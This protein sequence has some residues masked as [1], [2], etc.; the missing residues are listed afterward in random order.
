MA[1]L[2]T[3]ERQRA[4]RVPPGPRSAGRTTLTEQDVLRTSLVIYETRVYYTTGNPP[5][6]LKPPAPERVFL[7]PEST[8]SY[9]SL[10]PQ[11]T[12]GGGGGGEVVMIL[13]LPPNTSTRGV[14]TGNGVRNHQLVRL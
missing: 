6:S 10:E 7:A 13:S 1:K 8:V 2:G 5:P 14:S 12:G 11:E 3:L 4:K 9:S